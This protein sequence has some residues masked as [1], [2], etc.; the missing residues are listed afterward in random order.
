M[1]DDASAYDELFEYSNDENDWFE[2]DQETKNKDQPDNSISREDLDRLKP[3]YNNDKC[4]IKLETYS[5]KERHREVIENNGCPAHIMQT[6]LSTLVQYNRENSNTSKGTSFVVGWCP[7]SVAEVVR[8]IEEIIQ[9]IIIVEA[10][11]TIKNDGCIEIKGKM[12]RRPQTTLLN[13]VK[14]DAQR[15]F[16]IVKMKNYRNEIRKESYRGHL[17]RYNGKNQIPGRTV[18]LLNNKKKEIEHE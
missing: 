7:M 4:D 12:I 10:N 6:I 16:V 13:H 3:Y 5:K 1:E 9:K 17:I 8:W 2:E 15:R 11:F 18:F 14:F